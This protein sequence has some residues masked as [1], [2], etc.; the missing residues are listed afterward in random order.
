MTQ[1]LVFS[2]FGL[3]L[4]VCLLIQA[5]IKLSDKDDS[6]SWAFP[7]VISSILLIFSF[8]NVI[9]MSEEVNSPH[10]EDVISG[11][12]YYTESYH[13]INNDTIKTYRIIWKR[14]NSID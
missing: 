14:K 7:V 6:Y 3:I 8:A 13:V 9:T 1:V 11:K 12:A 4:S 2:I 5:I 10:T